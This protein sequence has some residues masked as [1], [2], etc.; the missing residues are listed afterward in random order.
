MKLKYLGLILLTIILLCLNIKEGLSYED[1]RQYFYCKYRLDPNSPKCQH[2]F[3]NLD[4]KRQPELVGI[5]YTK[6]EDND[7]TYNLYKSINDTDFG[8]NYYIKIRKRGGDYILKRI[9]SSKNELYSNQEINIPNHHN[10]PYVVQL[11]E[12]NNTNCRA[13]KVNPAGRHYL[14]KN[15]WHSVGTRYDESLIPWKNSGYIYKVNGKRDKFFNLYEKELDSARNNYRYYIHDTKQ[16]V[17]IMLNEKEQLQS[18]RLINI[19]GKGG[20]YKIHKYDMEHPSYP[21]L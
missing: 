18:D 2:I 10:N 1:K 11:Y 4:E 3:Q 12:N 17:K 14:C 8:Y 20:E 7:K 13:C 16:D 15:C 19:D 6:R 9:Y 5:I 21:I